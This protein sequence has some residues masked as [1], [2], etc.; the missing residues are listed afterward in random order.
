MQLAILRALRREL[1]ESSESVEMT[2]IAVS[3][4]ENKISTLKHDLDQYQQLR[5]LKNVGSN[6]EADLDT[7]KCP[8]CESDLY[9][10]LGNRTVKREPM[11]LE[12][13]IDFLKSQI[14]FFVSVRNKNID[15]LGVAGAF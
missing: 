13:N 11:T 12:E 3:D 14:D 9:D 1:E 5:R 15:Q 4:T 8:I 6:I 7:R 10:T 2:M